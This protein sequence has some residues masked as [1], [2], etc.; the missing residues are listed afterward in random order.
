MR[1]RQRSS[2]RSSAVAGLLLLLLIATAGPRAHA[3]QGRGTSPE[4]LKLVLHDSIQPISAGYVE[5]GLALAAQRHDAAVLLSLGTPGGLLTSTRQIVSA[6][7]RSP[8]PVIVYVE[9]TGARAASAGFFILESADVAAMAPGTN[10]GAAHPIVEGRT[11][12][13][14]LKKKVEEDALA[15]LRS[16]TEPRHRDSAAATSAVLE[17]KSYTAEEALQLHLITL[18][19]PSDAALLAALDGQTITRFT[20]APVQLHLHAAHVYAVPPSLRER[21]LTRLTNPN[22]AVL[23]LVFGALLIYIEFHAPGTV[24]PGALGTLC[25]LL[26][27]FALNLLPIAHFAVLL[28]VAALLLILLEVKFPSHGLL[29]LTGTAA[30]TIGLLTLVDGPPG[31]RVHPSVAIA[32]G[33]GFGSITFLLAALAA[34][35]RRNKTRLGPTAMLGLVGTVRTALDPAASRWQ[36]QVRGEL[37]QAE[38]A[39]PEL[40]LQPGQQVRV[41]AVRGLVLL[42]HPFAAV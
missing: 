30:L 10:T 17:A 18:I 21:L 8:V 14:V 39:S 25:V 20:G 34:R 11:M 28:L 7:E 26:A 4:V 23:L 27:L 38:A 36:V 13:P 22:L 5:R 40:P 12:D 33:V 32:V 1:F 3:A 24:I 15:L 2:F 19:Q 37:W 35:A 16:E 41:E 31:Q 29:A 6:I 42:V 9:P